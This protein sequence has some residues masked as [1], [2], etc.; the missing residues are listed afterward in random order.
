M[1]PTVTTL[2]AGWTRPPAATA[3]SPRVEW[4]D[5]NQPA[6]ITHTRADGGLVSKS[7]HEY[8]I[9]GNLT[10]T[11]TETPEAAGG[12]G[13][14]AETDYAYDTADRLTSSKTTSADGT[15]TETAYKLNAASDVTEETRTVTKPGG[16]AETTTVTREH[17]ADGRLTK[18]TT[19]A[20]D[21]KTREAVQEFDA[22]GNLLKD[23][24][25]NTFTYT[26]AG[27]LAATTAPGGT[28]TGHTYWPTGLR[29]TTTHSA[30]GGQGGE[31][32][33]S[34]AYWTP[35]APGASVPE[36]AVEETPDG[37]RASHL[38]AATRETRT[39][40]GSDGKPTTPD[41]AETGY[42]LHDRLGSTTHLTNTDGSVTTGYTYTDYGTTTRTPTNNG[43]SGGAAPPPRR[44][45]FTATPTPTPAPPPTRQPATTTSEAASTT[46]PPPTSPP[47]T[48]PT[49]STATP[50]QPPT[51]TSTPTKPATPPHARRMDQLRRRHRPR[52]H[53][54]APPPSPSLPPASPP[55]SPTP[56]SS[57]PPLPSTASSSPTPTRTSSPRQP[58]G[59]SSA[60]APPPPSEASSTV[61]GLQ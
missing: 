53:R 50:T 57:P 2:W 16:T 18:Q 59:P 36:T 31:K 7:S 24:D 23:A 6:V 51:P 11:V 27:H 60:S 4:D 14:T 39:L 17:D 56:P 35:Q 43:N 21:G 38:L 37:T 54:L 1:W 8:D 49:S 34:T 55:S 41:G 5:R 40:L 33:E 13:G 15:V 58:N 22:N 3:S 45:E 44:R 9:R 52:P 42:L 48:P 10:K 28:V 19:R 61:C 26:P 12:G 20:P 25:G 29:K 30:G 47:A 32:S 46:P